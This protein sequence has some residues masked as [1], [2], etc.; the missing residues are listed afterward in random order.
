MQSYKLYRDRDQTF[1]CQLHLDGSSIEKAKARIIIETKHSSLMFD[2]NINKTGKCRVPIIKLNDILNKD[3]NSGL[4]RL[5]VI[6][7]GA[8]F[9]IWKSPFTLEYAGNNINVKLSDL[10]EYEEEPEDVTDVLNDIREGMIKLVNAQTKIKNRQ[11]KLEETINYQVENINKNI[12]IISKEK[13]QEQSAR[14]YSGNSLHNIK[15][16]EEDEEYDNIVGHWGS[17]IKLNI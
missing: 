1:E 2:G 16:S 13:L 5:E 10:V 7:E 6:A 14:V 4:I 8:I 12:N 3:I 15:A 11:L 17:K 9:D